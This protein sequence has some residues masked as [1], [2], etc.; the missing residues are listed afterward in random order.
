MNINKILK[1]L[2]TLACYNALSL[3]SYSAVALHVLLHAALV[4]Y[5]FSEARMQSKFRMNRKDRIY[6]WKTHQ[7]H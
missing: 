5:D 7:V 2:V 4:L 3:H 1:C 6:T